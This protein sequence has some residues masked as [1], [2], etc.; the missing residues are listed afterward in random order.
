VH[1]TLT[2]VKRGGG[3]G[4]PACVSV[5]DLAPLFAVSAANLATD[6]AVFIL[7]V[8]R[9]LPMINVVCLI[10]HAPPAADVSDSLD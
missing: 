4:A 8:S 2:L 5:I 3:S 7:C 9:C 1:A 10:R 6:L